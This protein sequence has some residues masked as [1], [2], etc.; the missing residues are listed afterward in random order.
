MYALGEK[1]FE[2]A[3]VDFCVIDDGPASGLTLNLSTMNLFGV[4]SFYKK[5][6]RLV[7]SAKVDSIAKE[8]MQVVYDESL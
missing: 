7:T 1:F 4:P 2:T 5:T 8:F 3:D 6:I